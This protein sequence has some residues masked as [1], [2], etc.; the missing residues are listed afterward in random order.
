MAIVH[1]LP[2]H[3]PFLLDCEGCVSLSSGVATHDKSQLDLI[4]TCDGCNRQLNTFVSFDDM[5]EL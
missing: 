5:V 4:V 1:T 3:C 2:I